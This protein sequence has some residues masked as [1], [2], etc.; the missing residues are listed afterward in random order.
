MVF[1]PKMGYNRN[2]A[3]A[4]VYGPAKH[5]GIGIKHLYAEQSIAQITALIQHTRLCSPLGRTICINLD[6]VQIIAGIQRP[7]LEDTQP[8]QHMEGKWFKSI[9][10]FLHKTACT[11][12]IDGL[13]TPR[14][15][16][17][18]DQCI[19][20]AL[21]TSQDAMRI[22]RVRIYLQ[23]TTIADI[24]NAEG[25]HITE[26]VFGGRNSRTAENPRQT[27]NGQDNHDRDQKH[28]KHG[29]KHSNPT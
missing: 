11:I 21:R 7:V 2:T 12:R 5:G 17:L 8:I 22:N 15:Q 29:E 18:H 26:Y 3:R 13:W 23:A 20:D 16:R 6:W 19:M 24:A 27:K 10:E 25:T 1:L 9:R 4:V 14:V 28:G